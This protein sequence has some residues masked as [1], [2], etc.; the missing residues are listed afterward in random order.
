[1]GGVIFRVQVPGKMI[2]VSQAYDTHHT[3]HTTHHTPHTT[4]GTHHTPHTTH[5][6]PHT[7]GEP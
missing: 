4:H 7:S 1:M 5:H 3:P 2:E 6:T